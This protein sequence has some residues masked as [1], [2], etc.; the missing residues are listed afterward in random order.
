MM[1]VLVIGMVLIALATLAFSAANT[2]MT[3]RRAAQVFS[4][5]LALARS[6]AVRGREKVTVKFN[7]ASRWYEVRTASGR[8]VATRRFGVDDEV[9]LS[10]I[11]L[12]LPG[13]SLVFSNRGVGTLSGSLGTASFTA[14]AI[15]YQV[16]FN[17]IGAAQVAEL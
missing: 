13:D 3:A 17:A 2:R 15:T 16:S 6:I 10:A 14:G 12:D 5:D 8:T 7:E 1:V 4:R 11:T 9:N